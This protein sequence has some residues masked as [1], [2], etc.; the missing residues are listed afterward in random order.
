MNIVDMDCFN[1][2]IK[3]TFVRMI[4]I[5]IHTVGLCLNTV[6][7]HLLYC[8]VLFTIEECLFFLVVLLFPVGC[9]ILFY[10]RLVY[11]LFSNYKF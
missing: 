11:S 9:S 2:F 5:P 8:L 1:I 4:Q 6:L 10:K 3:F 7:R